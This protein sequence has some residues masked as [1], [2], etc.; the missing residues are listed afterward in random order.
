[1]QLQKLSC[2]PQCYACLHGVLLQ[3]GTAPPSS[4]TCHARG[5]SSSTKKHP[6]TATVTRRNAAD[7]HLLRVA[8]VLP[9][10]L[11]GPV[12]GCPHFLHQLGHQALRVQRVLQAVHTA[13]AV[14]AVHS[15]TISTSSTGINKQHKGH[16][17]CNVCKDTKIH[18]PSMHGHKRKRKGAGSGLLLLLLLF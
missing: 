15:S 18:Q 1:M 13:T 5:S 14:Q 17:T 8:C 16:D 7:T 6:T 3:G 10:M 4:A 11:H 9:H 2:L 12:K